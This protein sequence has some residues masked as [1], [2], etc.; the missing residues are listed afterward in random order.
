VLVGLDF[1]LAAPGCRGAID[2]DSSRSN[3]VAG[4]KPHVGLCRTGRCVLVYAV[5][6]FWK[7]RPVE[8][9]DDCDRAFVSTGLGASEQ[10]LVVGAEQHLP[11]ELTG[12]TLQG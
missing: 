7:R 9:A 2:L 12:A 5:R 10:V 11:T 8:I 1:T 3:D 6:R 4:K